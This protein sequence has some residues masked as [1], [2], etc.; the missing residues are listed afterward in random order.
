MTTKASDGQEP[1]DYEDELSATPSDDDGEEEKPAWSGRTSKIALAPGAN[2]NRSFEYIGYRS[3][4]IDCKAE[5][6]LGRRD[7]QFHAKAQKIN[8]VWSEGPEAAHIE[9]L[10]HQGMLNN[11]HEATERLAREQEIANIRGVEKSPYC[12]ACHEPIGRDAKGELLGLC[13][14]NHRNG[15]EELRPRTLSQMKKIWANALP[16]EKAQSIERGQLRDQLQGQLEAA[17]AAGMVSLAAEIREALAE[18]K[19]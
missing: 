17:V 9:D 1:L 16:Y 6:K 18:R 3:E 19:K 13:P 11:T 8:G 14:N 2:L 10:K 12:P 5:G 15:L 7:H 4:C